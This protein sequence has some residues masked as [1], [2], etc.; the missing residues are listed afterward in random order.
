M[1]DRS[2]SLS[3]RALIAV[4]LVVLAATPRLA[5]QRADSTLTVERIFGTGEF[6]A[7]RLSGARWRPGMDAYTRLER[8]PG[9]T[10]ARS[11]PVRCG[12]RSSRGDPPGV[13]TRSAGRADHSRW[14]STIG[15]PTAKRLLLFTNSERVWRENTRGDYWLIDLAAGTPR[16]LGGRAAK[17]S[18]LMFAKFSPDGGRV[19]YVRENNLYVED[20]ATGRITR[21]RA[22][23]RARSSTAPSTGCTRKSSPCATASAGARTASA[24]RTG[25]STRPGV[26]DY[27][28]DRRHRLA[29]LV[30]RSG[31]VPEGG[32]DQLRGPRRRR[33]R[34]RR[35]DPLDRHAGRPAQQLH[36]AHGVGRQARTRSCSS[37]STGCS[38]RSPSCSATRAPARRV[39]F[40][41]SATA[42]GSTSSNDLRWLDGGRSF[43]WV[44][45]RDGWRHLYV[46]SR[47][48]KSVRLV[49]PGNFDIQNP[50][51]LFGEREVLGV[52]ERAGVVYFTASPDNPT[53]LY[54]YAAP[55]DGSGTV[56]RV[57]PM[58]APGTHSY[59]IAPSGRFALHTASSFGVPPVTDLVRLPQSRGRAHA[60][61]QRRVARAARRHRP[62]A[63]GVLSRRRW[64]RLPARRLDDQAARL[65][66]DEAS[67]PCSST[68][69]ASRPTRPC[70]TRGTVDTYLWHL[71]LAQQGY[72]VAS[73]DNRGT[74]SPRGRFWRKRIYGAVGD[75][76]VARA[77]RRGARPRASPVRGLRRGSACGDGAAAAR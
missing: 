30:R 64:K 48:G 60:D 14:R 69:T 10:R 25:S 38:I 44:S 31:A 67:I 70:A 7:R 47:D 27:R 53:Q 1:L 57:T 41:S 65:R 68:C 28:P 16:K 51:S 9:S 74:P 46:V 23:A 40:S 37:T 39:P 62:R 73:I 2:A 13:A 75:A 5:A 61:R 15:R 21:S 49:T 24:S 36:R 77:G 6:A 71:M 58:S 76:R 4:A 19:A 55:L 56:Q 34:R 42:H 29:L 20:L 35:T 66:L 59:I 22:T 3:A 54:L 12:V 18:T 32:H 26:R 63:G 50:L 8:S 43:T 72:I 52:D 11:R 33:E 45:E 17:P